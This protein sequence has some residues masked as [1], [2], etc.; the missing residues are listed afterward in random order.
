MGFNFRQALKENGGVN[1]LA[2]AVRVSHQ[3]I[4][5]WREVPPKR[6]LAVEKAWGISRHLIRP[7]I[8]G[9]EPSAASNP[10]PCNTAAREAGSSHDPNPDIAPRQ[11]AYASHA[12][13]SSPER[14]V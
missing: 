2:T 7:D 4:S 6:V 11:S 13:A 1:A 5:Q 14:E 8:Y 9:P 12:P 10:S 3:A